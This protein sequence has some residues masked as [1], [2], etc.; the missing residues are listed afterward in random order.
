MLKA[1]NWSA[2]QKVLPAGD[3]AVGVGH[4]V[5][6]AF[7]AQLLTIAASPLL[8]RLYNPEDFGLLAAFTGALMLTNVV[9]RMRY[10][11]AIPLSRSDLV[12]ANVSALALLIAGLMSVIFSIA[13]TFHEAWIYQ[14]FRI[15]GIEAVFWL[16]PVGVFFAGAYVVFSYWATRKRRFLSIAQARVQQSATTLVAQLAS[17]GFGGVSLLVG[18][19]AGHVVGFLSLSR[20]LVNDAS[21]TKVSI[22]GMKRVACRYRRFPLFYGSGG[23]LN[24]AGQYIT[25]LVFAISFGA[26]STGLYALANR[27][28]LLPM[29][30]VGN[31]VGQA[32]FPSAV[33]AYR[34]GQLRGSVESLHRHLCEFGLPPIFLMALAAP[35]LFAFVFGEAWRQ[36]GEYARWMAPWMYWQLVSSPLSTVFAVAEEQHRGL[37]FQA[38]L[39]TLQCVA[40][41]YGV[42][43]A[44]LFTAILILSC[45]SSLGY[46]L[47]LYLIFDTSGVRISLIVTS[48]LRAGAGS[49][50]CAFPLILAEFVIEVSLTIYVMS[51]VLS[52]TLVGLRYFRL[53]RS[54]SVKRGACE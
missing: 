31:S 30:L 47:L 36:S 21:A 9:S 40:I 42:Y 16:F 14:Y 33:D 17:Y 45:F 22:A 18:Y 4:L 28:L 11:M 50:F 51:I 35:E 39:F 6:G 37:I 44:D 49:L 15:N 23:L 29:G 13:L 3:F 1:W 19:V 20:I 25:P 54:I 27:I 53:L 2:V 26:V 46:L 43:I 34:L 48:T 41:A 52:L 7:V 5:G 12:A 32:F 10:E 24:S 8:T 38:S